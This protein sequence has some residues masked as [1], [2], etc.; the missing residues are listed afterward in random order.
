MEETPIPNPNSPI[1]PDCYNCVHRLPG[2]GSHHSMCNN[3]KA[4]VTVNRHGYEHGWAT[5]PFD[6][7]PIWIDSCDSFKP[8]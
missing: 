2:F 5:W 7:D 8:K 1:K 6:F 4:S 3:W